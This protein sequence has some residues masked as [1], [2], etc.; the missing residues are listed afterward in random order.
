[1]QIKN[2]DKKK[3]SNVLYWGYQMRES[4][5]F[6]IKFRKKNVYHLR[7]GIIKYLEIQKKMNHLWN[8]EC[9]VFDNR[10]SLNKSLRKGNFSLCYA[11]RN[12]FNRRR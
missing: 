10:V 9:F 4:D 11:C 7:G 8:G 12:A 3:N 5:F 2:L 6:F 1:M